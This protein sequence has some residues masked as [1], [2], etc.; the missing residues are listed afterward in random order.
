MQITRSVPRGF[1]SDKETQ[2]GVHS[3]T[4]HDGL[5]R[6]VLVGLV[7]SLRQHSTPIDMVLPVFTWDWTVFGT[8]HSFSWTVVGT[9]CFSCFRRMRGILM[10]RARIEINIFPCITFLSCDYEVYAR[11]CYRH[12]VC[13]S[14]RPSVRLSVCLSNACIVTKRDNIL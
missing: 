7:T 10:Y 13:L 1:S 9:V 5:L 6:G 12:Y 3:C 8:V 14:V 11:Y 4:Y 2:P